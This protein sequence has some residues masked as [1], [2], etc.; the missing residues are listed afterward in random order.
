MDIGC[1]RLCMSPKHV[2]GIGI[3]DVTMGKA[4]TTKKLG[5]NCSN[6]RKICGVSS[7]GTYKDVGNI[8]E[9]GLIRME[10]SSLVWNNAWIKK[11]LV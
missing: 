1:L 6:V 3:K 7:Q 9:E 8:E 5:G 4:L 2:R 11:S 10:G